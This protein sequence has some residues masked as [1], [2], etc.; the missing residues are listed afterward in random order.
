MNRKAVRIVLAVV[1]ILGIWIG[2]RVVLRIA[3]QSVA[4]KRDAARG[5]IQ[6]NC[7]KQIVLAAFM[8]EI[9]YGSFP[10]ASIGKNGKPLLSW[11]VAILPFL[12]EKDL[13]DRFHLDEPWDSPHNLKVAEGMPGVFH[14][15]YRKTKDNKTTIMVFSGK[16]TAFNGNR[17]ICDIPD[18]RSHTIFCVAAATEKAVIWT[19]PED[20]QFDPVQPLTALGISEDDSFRAAFFDGSVQHLAV[21]N[22]TLA[23]L[24][25]PDGGETVEEEQPPFDW[26]NPKDAPIDYSKPTRLVLK[27]TKQENK[28]AKNASHGGP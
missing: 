25:T 9:R 12:D 3:I 7:L 2:V 11:R 27:D 15:P 5:A 1:V 20:L 17:G 23:A 6:S 22:P 16:G 10:P 24:I 18:G 14:S 21:D 28:N 13:Y 19:K 8:Y 26:S 4:A